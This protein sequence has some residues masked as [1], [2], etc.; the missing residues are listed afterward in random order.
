MDDKEF[1]FL[2]KC[3]YFNKE[4]EICDGVVVCKTTNLPSPM[5]KKEQI[6]FAVIPKNNLEKY[7][8]TIHYN[9]TS[10][11]IDDSIFY[12]EGIFKT[13]DDAND[14]ILKSLQ[15]KKERIKKELIT[16]NEKIKQAKGVANMT[17]GEVR[18]SY[19]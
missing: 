1:K 7:I 9:K 5:V 18:S 4:E 14:F 16:V 19:D 11:T 3:F 12:A 13:K 17:I 10:Y 8:E 6:V 2:E 15:A